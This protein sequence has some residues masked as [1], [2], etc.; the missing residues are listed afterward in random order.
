MTGAGSTVATVRSRFASVTRRV[1]RELLL[2][3]RRIRGTAPDLTARRRSACIDTGP[4]PDRSPVTWWH[5][6]TRRSSSAP[7]LTPPELGRD[8]IAVLCATNRPA[9]IDDLVANI[10]R[11]TLVHQLHAVIVLNESGFDAAGVERRLT[12]AGCAQVTVLSLPPECTLGECLRSG[13][14]V[15]D[16]RY[17]AK[18]DDDDTYGPRHLAES[19]AAL[20]WSGAAVTGKQTYLVHIEETGETAV[21]FP[22][23]DWRFVGFV[24]GGTIVMDRW[25]IGTATFGDAN[26]GEDS[27]FLAAVERNGGLILSNS[28]LGYVQFRGSSNT[29]CAAASDLLADA[30]VV[31][32]GDVRPLVAAG[33]DDD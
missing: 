6:E 1:R 16:A 17:V 32:R 33:P 14:A 28:A 11:Q 22:G 26:T 7:A 12:A 10:A 19:V 20:A 31:G 3:R 15:T 25:A 21:R 5:R 9:N 4:T 30:V 13:L 27:A 8:G 2:A 23:R 24:A 29:W 18:F